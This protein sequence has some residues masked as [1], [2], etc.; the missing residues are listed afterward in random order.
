ME[1]ANTVWLLAVLLKGLCVSLLSVMWRR[2]GITWQEITWFV[3]LVAAAPI[4][5]VGLLITPEEGSWMLLS[6]V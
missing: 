1:C 2:S 6:M 4:F 3:R 5:A